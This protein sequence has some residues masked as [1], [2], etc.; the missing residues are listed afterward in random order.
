M[1]QIIIT[2]SW[3]DGH[4]LDVR[5]SALLKKYGIKGT[6]YISPRD[7]EF[8]PEERLT[9]DQVRQLSRDFEIGAHTM[10]H[11]RLT[12]VSDTVARKEIVDSKQY[13]ERLLKKP[14]TTF[15]YPGGNYVAKHVAIV[16]DAGFAYA[17]T[18]RRH[19]FNLKGSLL[20]NNTTINAYIHYQDLWKIARFTHFNPI[21]T[22]QYFQWDALAKAMFDRVLQEGGVY[23]LWGH[24][25]EIDN[26]GDWDKLED[27][28]SYISK[29]RE[30]QYVTNGE[31]PALQPKRILITAT[32]FPPHLGGVEFYTY[33]LAKRLQ[34]LHGWQ[35]SIATSGNKGWR[36]VKTAYEGITVYRLPYW[37][38][39]S[40][41]PIS[42]FWPSM[43]RRIIAEEDIYII[44]AHA[45][46][47]G[48][49]D[50][51]ALVA[52]HAH[53]PF[54]VTYHMVSMTK[55]RLLTD[56]I[57]SV[58]EKRVLP[59]MLRYASA[60]ICASDPVRDTFL[61]KQ[62]SKSLTVTPGVDTALFTPAAVA[63]ENTL[64]YVGS[65]AKS[66]KHKG[67]HVLLKAMK[68]VVKEW[69][70]ARLMLVGE[71]DGRA[72]YEALAMR[73]GL[74]D[75]VRF[76]GGQ[77]GPDL[78]EAYREASV[79]VLPSFNE[80]FGMVVL[81]AMASGIPV[82]STP[83]GAIPMQ[84]TDDQNGYLVQPGDSAMLAKKLIYL[85]QHPKIARQFGALGRQRSESGFS[86]EAKSAK[87]DEVL[88]AVLHGTY[89]GEDATEV[90]T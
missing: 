37:L 10:T 14:V 45:P 49:A 25:W 20:E 11:P 36:M 89:K 61:R 73:Y 41:S 2:T 32:Y 64:L 4:V 18:V 86:W 72:D 60:V 57:I 75:N 7:H 71:G 47:P 59:N 8:K 23:H 58:Y 83:V 44:N 66:D 28:L 43:L 82:V 84:I 40:N 26:H 85:L 38:K 19:C 6:F 5:L 88:E 74:S 39:L 22:Y 55:G 13:L 51:A 87:T 42:P 48:L 21:R 80:S 63:P 70:E 3:D 16:R 34:E 27:V 33:Y 77:Y 68:T 29:H 15:C 50:M 56:R 52:F 1:K 31:L 53:I 78:Y 81:E 79:F 76:L 46:V 17:R 35:V 65:L 12:E 62:R 9:D 24:S 90:T 54:A 67:V 69:P 30:V